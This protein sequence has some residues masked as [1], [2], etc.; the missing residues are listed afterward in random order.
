M[1]VE[2]LGIALASDEVIGLWDDSWSIAV[3]GPSRTLPSDTGPSGPSRFPDTPWTQILAFPDGSPEQRRASLE[4]LFRL[5]WRPVYAFIRMR[6]RKTREDARD[7]TQQ[8]IAYLLERGFPVGADAVR[9]RFRAYLQG[10]LQHFLLREHEAKH[11]RKRG[12]GVSPVSLDL[13]DEPV[14]TPVSEEMTA[15]QAFD[16]LWMQNLLQEALERVRD[17]CRVRDVGSRFELFEAHDLSQPTPTFAEL[18]ARFALTEHQ[19]RRAIRD[20]REMLREALRR[21]IRETVGRVEDVDEELRFLF[22]E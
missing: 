13:R 2:A 19:V 11:R 17:L 5:Y 10:A 7:S 22:G 3:A 4:H 9:G 8:F 6:W 12:G 21:R 20:V 18:G 14:F 16:R 1:R 15:A